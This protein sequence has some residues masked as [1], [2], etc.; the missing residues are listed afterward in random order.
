MAAS[1]KKSCLVEKILKVCT[2][3]AGGRLSNDLQVYVLTKR[4]TLSMHLKNS[5]SS[6]YI[7]IANVDL[8]VETTGTQQRTVKY[9][10]TVCCSHDD[11]AFVGAKT[12]HFNQQLVKGLLSFVMSA[13]QTCATLAAYGVDFVNEDDCGS[14]LLGLLKEV[15][16]AG[17]TDTD[18]K[19]N[20]VGTGNRQ[21][22]NACFTRNSL[23]KKSL[24]G[25]GRAYK[26]NALRNTGTDLN[27]ALGILEELNNLFQLFFFLVSACNIL[28]CN[29]VFLG[30]TYA[31]AGLT[32]FH[33]ALIAATAALIHEDKPDYYEYDHYNQIR[34]EGKPP[35]SFPPGKII[36]I[37][38]HTCSHLTVDKIVHILIEY[39]HAV[40]FMGYSITS[41]QR[42]AQI[43]DKHI[44]FYYEGTHLLLLEKT[45]HIKITEGIAFITGHKHK[46]N[47]HDNDE[48]HNVKADIQRPILFLFVQSGS[49]LTRCKS[50]A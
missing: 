48:D 36:V 31:G 34:Q 1:C 22:L 46:N 6:L 47:C 17:C 19:F 7:G 41:V 37:F 21:E 9:I 10:L 16:D 28:E 33:N 24:T 40:Q 23:R 42:L 14:S 45:A 50:P 30:R 4:L 3:K 27:E 11:Y 29:L 44:A 49:L 8:P 15:S 38:K 26:Q 35:G 32:E 43:H 18:I 25:T 39:G 13:A 20:E 5:F 2:C 12:V